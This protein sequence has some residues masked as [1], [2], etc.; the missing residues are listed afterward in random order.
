MNSSKM[1]IKPR[2]SSVLVKPVTQ[3]DKLGGLLL[4]DTSKQERPNEGSV[5]SVGPKVKDL[6]KGDKIIF[7]PYGFEEYKMEDE[8]VYLMEEKEIYAT[9]AA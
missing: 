3:Q 4:P 1:K 8:K 7:N 6:K 5:L 9:Y 2:G